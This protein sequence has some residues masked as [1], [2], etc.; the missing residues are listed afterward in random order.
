MAENK[1]T[2]FVTVEIWSLYPTYEVVMSKWK[3]QHIVLVIPTINFVG[4]L[5][6]DSKCCSNNICENLVVYILT[7]ACAPM[8]KNAYSVSI[9]K[10]TLCA[11]MFSEKII[12]IFDMV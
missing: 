3:Q 5:P 7:M 6:S 11:D 10:S 4:T 12:I 2:L 1:S 8:K 9:Q